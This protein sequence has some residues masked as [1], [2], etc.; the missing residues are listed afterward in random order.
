MTSGRRLSFGIFTTLLVAGVMAFA[1]SSQKM[2]QIAIHLQLAAEPLLDAVLL[3]I[4][5]EAQRAPALAAGFASLVMVPLLAVA[6]RLG[7][8]R[9]PAPPGPSVPRPE[10]PVIR[11]TRAW[12]TPA[13]G[14][15]GEG[16]DLQLDGEVFRIGDAEENDAVLP[17]ADG[18]AGMQAIIRR[19]P[20]AEFVL[21]GLGRQPRSTVLVNGA[22]VAVARLHDGDRISVGDTLFT[23][24]R[25]DGT[26]AV[27][28]ASA[29]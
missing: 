1:S 2:S 10:P 20:E 5:T 12:L 7:R 28:P 4:R 8:V 11:R 13:A 14:G 21:L 15:D 17:G 25:T 24:R 22:P 3:S 19:T 16:R 9:R 29:N 23:F 18:G 27:A 6:A 26:P